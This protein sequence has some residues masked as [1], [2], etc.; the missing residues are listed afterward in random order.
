MLIKLLSGD[1][2]CE[3]RAW[4][5]AH[6]YSDSWTRADT[7]FD[8]VRWKMEHSNL[9]W[10]SRERLED[11]GYTVRVEKENKF[12][13]D[14]ACATVSGQPNLVVKKDIDITVMDV[15]TGTPRQWD[16]IQV[17][18]Y[19][20]GLDRYV[21]AW[22]DITE[23]EGGL[24]RSWDIPAYA[25]SSEFIEEIGSLIR[26]V[27]DEK[28]ALLVPSSAEC[29]FC[30]ITLEECLQRISVPEEA[31]PLQSKSPALCC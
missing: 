7:S 15:K 23:G 3:W 13:V 11:D 20:F 14:G 9:L 27:A 4:F 22:G 12:W 18:L 5:Q 24:Q 21:T 17:M 8:S 10:E 6:H 2:W 25:I 1:D 19:M 16:I 29:G 31:L 30:S 26:R 28:P